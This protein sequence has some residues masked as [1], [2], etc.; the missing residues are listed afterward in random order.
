M[1]GKEKHDY[2]QQE[3]QKGKIK[4]YKK[5]YQKLQIFRKDINGKTGKFQND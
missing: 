4:G 1:D 5:T 2:Y 3:I